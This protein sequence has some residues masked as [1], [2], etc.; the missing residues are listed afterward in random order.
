MWSVWGREMRGNWSIKRLHSFLKV[1]WPGPRPSNKVLWFFPEN[2]QSHPRQKHGTRLSS[3]CQPPPCS[4]GPPA[5]K[6]RHSLPS[7]P[8]HLVPRE[9]GLS[10]LHNLLMTQWGWGRTLLSHF[11]PKEGVI[12]SSLHKPTVVLAEMPSF[13]HKISTRL[14]VT[15]TLK[16]AH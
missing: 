5:P 3:H 16:T 13:W 2:M 6:E 4:W 11:Q 1:T 8:A 9:H 14:I 7:L 10:F 12:Y 15:C